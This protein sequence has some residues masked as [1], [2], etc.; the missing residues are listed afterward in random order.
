LSRKSKTQSQ[1]DDSMTENILMTEEDVRAKLLLPYLNDLG[2]DVSEIQLERSFS[3]RIGKSLRTITGRADIL[4]K[5]DGKNLFV[6]ELK[7]A[8]VNIT[9]ADIDQGISYARLLEDNIAPFAIITNGKTTKI[10][11]TIS[12]TELT[13]RIS[14]Q[15]LFWRNGCSLGLDEDLSIRYEALKHFVTFSPENLKAFCAAQV[16]NRMGSVIGDIHN[17]L[18]KFIRELHVTR[19]DL[20]KSFTD[21]LVGDRKVFAITG[22]AG[23]GKT[24]A[25]CSL[26]LQNLEEAFVFFYNG[27]IIG[28]SPQEY[29]ARDLNLFFSSRNESD[30]ILKKLDEIGRKI[31]RNILIFI[32]AIDE[33]VYP[34][35]AVELSEMA[36]AARNLDKV[37]ICI[38]CKTNVWKDFVLIRNTKTHLFEELGKTHGIV[39]P[40]GNLP[41][42]VLEDFNDHE[43][44]AII[45]IYKSAFGFRGAISKSLSK[46][47]RNGFFLKIFSEVYTDKEIPDTISDKELISKYLRQSLD[48]AGISFETGVRNLAKIAKALMSHQYTTMEIFKD[49][50]LEIGQL[51][52]HLELESDGNLPEDLFTRNILI[53]SARED[54][55]HVSFYYS[56]IRDY[57]IGFHTYRLDKLKADKLYDILSDFYA[58]H[59]GQ[60]AIA[61][62]IENASSEH[63][64]IIRR[65][66][67]DKARTYIEGYN[68]YLDTH[69]APFKEMFD[70]KTAGEIGIVLPKDLLRKDGYALY[71]L[72]AGTSDKVA[73]EDLDHFGL[74]DRHDLFFEMGVSTIYGGNSTIMIADQHKTIAENV[75]KELKE[76]LHKGKFVTH[77]SATLLK[78]AVVAILYNS[79][80]KL[81]CN[82]VFED[83]YLP[84]PEPLYPLDLKTL[85]TKLYRLKATNYYKGNGTAPRDVESMVD[86]AV[87]DNLILP[88]YYVNGEYTPLETLLRIVDLLLDKGIVEIREHLLPL[89]DKTIAETTLFHQQIREFNL[90]KIR[91]AQYSPENAK[92]YVEA[93]FRL[94]E[95]SYSEFVEFYFPTFKERFDFYTTMPHDYFFLTKDSDVRNWGFFGRRPSRSGKLT[96]NFK[97]LV[98]FGDKSKFEGGVK[99]FRGFSLDSIIHFSDPIKS[100]NWLNERNIDE[101]CVLRNWVLQLL[102]EDMRGIFEENGQ[103]I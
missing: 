73:Y 54:S 32:D 11:D 48:K 7:K 66:K 37:K 36:L 28:G 38:S 82:Y 63:L 100:S 97:E 34:N 86:K 26:A 68:A 58:N 8:S 35:L 5:R 101:R 74:S 40:E 77:G 15:S 50:G 56:K 51:L 67:G 23:V 87:T 79:H 61:F 30:I 20:Q 53:K 6:I 96:V 76:I 92:L 13:G 17:P 80:K 1:N 89:P 42:F 44:K 90:R 19:E 22:S 70:P 21:F 31:D 59:I 29:I 60:S 10:F 25:M 64:D 27:T 91:P 41:G 52:D 57:I 3:I 83:Y 98:P 84:R 24:G 71:P 39:T 16:T 43:I 14:E 4:C 69:L 55:Y 102:K 49:D 103:R 94:L 95:Q 85:Q 72:P 81:G 33:N 2:F 93:F 75:F 78:E 45:P 99:S 47:L 9:K 65:F 46:E 18:S 88:T 62:Y 12:R